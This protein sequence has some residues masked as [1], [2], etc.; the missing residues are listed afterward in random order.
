MLDLGVLGTNGS[1]HVRYQRRENKASSEAN[2]FRSK[3][4]TDTRKKDQEWV[5]NAFAGNQ[6][7]AFVEKAT[8]YAITNAS[9]QVGRVW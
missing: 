9:K 6:N 8:Y 3:L 1:F 2:I 5:E 7:I 4:I